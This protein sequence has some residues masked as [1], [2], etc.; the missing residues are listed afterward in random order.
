MKPMT[1]ARHK[2]SG[3]LFKFVRVPV[4][5]SSEL[6]YYFS[7]N[8]KI[9]T[10]LDSSNRMTIRCDEPLTLGFLIRNITDANN[11]LILSDMIWQITG[12]QPVVNAFNTIDSYTMLAVKFQGTIEG[13]V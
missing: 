12:I 3:E 6:K 10:G 2:F 1:I 5:D 13:I 8:I 11:D 4:G 7:K 9:T